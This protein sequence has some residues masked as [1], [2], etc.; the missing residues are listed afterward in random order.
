MSAL[1][2]CPACARHVRAVE[3]VCPFCEAAL[4]EPAPRTFD[5]ARAT[6]RAALV[7]AT[8]AA[9]TVS[10]CGKKD[11]GGSSGEA[12]AVYGPPPQLQEL[13]DASPNVTPTPAK[14]HDAAAD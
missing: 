10:A 12:V 11:G 13:R 4:P 3:I 5:H 6:G 2:P 9:I 8:A 1:H 7:F 14:P